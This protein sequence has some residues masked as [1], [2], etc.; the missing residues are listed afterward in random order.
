VAPADL[1]TW[2]AQPWRAAPLVAIDLE[3]S[4]AQDGPDEAILE[5]AAIRLLDGVPDT[6]TAC[7]TLINPGRPIPQRPWISPGLNAAAL[8]EAPTLTMVEPELARRLNGRILVGHNINVD[9]RLLHRRCP[10]IT[11]AGLL[12]TYKLARHVGQPRPHG[13]TAL[14]DALNLTTRANAATPSSQPHRALWDTAGAALLLT[15]LT[16]RY[17]PSEP[18]LDTVHAACGQPL[19]STAPHRSTQDG[20]PRLF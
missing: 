1:A 10:S 12:D 15:A 18:T 19:N 6:A 16:T 5:I 3:G 20:D 2:A 14:L 9:W 13:L 11:P 4:G 17:W 7:T 8:A